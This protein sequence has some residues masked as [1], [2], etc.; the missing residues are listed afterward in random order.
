[1]SEI[2][3]R[4]QPYIQLEEAIKSSVNQSLKGG[5]DGKK[6]KLQQE[7]PTH[8]DRI[9]VTGLQKTNVPDPLSEF[10]LDFQ[11]GTTLHFAEAP[12]QRNL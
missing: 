11:D 12:D 7:P 5:N 9:G 4:A 2:L 3:S 8:V 1:M 6:L 10:T